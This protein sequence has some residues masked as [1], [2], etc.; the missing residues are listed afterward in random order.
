MSNKSNLKSEW[1]FAKEVLQSCTDLRHVCLRV[2]GIAPPTFL[3]NL[4]PAAASNHLLSIKITLASDA[5][6]A[7][8]LDQAL[9]LPAFRNLR[10]F[11]LASFL[12]QSWLTPEIR[13]RMPLA[14]ARGI[15]E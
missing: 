10:S 7:E 13:A 15:L 11:S 14:S 3:P 5:F 9:A 2:E 8:A 1:D 12:Y 4:L 6:T